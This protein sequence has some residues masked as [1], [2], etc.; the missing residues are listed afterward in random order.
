MNADLIVAVRGR[1]D[2][3]NKVIE[4]TAPAKRVSNLRE[5]QTESASSML[6]ESIMVAAI[7]PVAVIYSRES[8]MPDKSA[9]NRPFASVKPLLKIVSFDM[10]T[11]IFS[12]GL[13]SLFLKTA[14]RISSFL[15]NDIFTES[16]Y[17]V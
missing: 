1:I 7:V 17:P 4:L 10:H 2:E 11:K 9:S 3:L 12:A 8:P 5:T 6:N 16:G 13:P 15:F 14:E